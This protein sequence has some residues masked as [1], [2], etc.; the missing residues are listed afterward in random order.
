MNEVI[1][2]SNRK[3]AAAMLRHARPRARWLDGVPGTYRRIM[4]RVGY[5][6]HSKNGGVLP[7]I[8]LG[9]YLAIV[10]I[11]VVSNM[12]SIIVLL[13]TATALLPAYVISHVVYDEAEVHSQEIARQG[14]EIVRADISGGSGSSLLFP[15]QE[16][17]DEWSSFVT[18]GDPLRVRDATMRLAALL[19]LK[20][21]G[22][23]DPGQR[24]EIARAADAVLSSVR[25]LPP[26]ATPAPSR[27]DLRLMGRI[28]GDGTS[29]KPKVRTGD[30]HADEIAF[31]A[32]EALADDPHLTDSHGGRIDRL[33][34]VDLPRL[35]AERDAV[36]QHASEARTR[37][38]LA[39]Y[40]Q[41]IAAIEHSVAEALDA[42]QAARADALATRVRFL[43]Q[44][45]GE[46]FGRTGGI[47]ADM[48]QAGDR[49]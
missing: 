34:D 2:K 28:I 30:A 12:S 9:L 43:A 48:H 4:R 31:I 14:A 36:L 1:A 25:K 16:S 32:Q 40:A 24:L 49:T 22:R 15:T 46:E 7:G 35:V 38:T 13:L 19:F 18:S 39:D 21:A 3:Q 44:R 41:G 6:L 8:M 27:S 42:W 17:M 20:S 26:P 45:R 10:V 5:E 47:T 33:V 37:S 11:A 23:N 29:I